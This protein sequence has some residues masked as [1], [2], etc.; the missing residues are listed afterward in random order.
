MISIFD[1]DK[2]QQHS[3]AHALLRECL[4]RCGIAYT[5]NTLIARGGYGKPSLAEYPEVCFNLSHAKGIAACIVSDRECGIDCEQVREFRPNVLK[6][7]F[8]ENERLLVENASPD[9]RGLMFFR[10]WTL[11]EAFVKALGIGI[12]YP[13]D[14]AEF[15][16]DGGR[17]LTDIRGYS[18]RQYI[19]DNGGFVVSVCE[20]DCIPQS[21]APGLRK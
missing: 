8:S 1:T 3:H 6:R 18:F 17:I 16:F 21:T 11:K 7:A 4:K 13:L 12:S 2:K 14:T 10:L 15:S 9:S 19:I 5:P 20:K